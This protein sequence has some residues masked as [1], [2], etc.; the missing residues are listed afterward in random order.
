[1]HRKLLVYPKSASPAL[2]KQAELDVLRS[3]RRGF[4]RF[5]ESFTNTSWNFILTRDTDEIHLKLHLALPGRQPGA[6]A[7]GS[8]K[9]Q[10]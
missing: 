10:R 7:G 3:H 2:H 9:L 1:M 6:G 5:F 8:H 4:F